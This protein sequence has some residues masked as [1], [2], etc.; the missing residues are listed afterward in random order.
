MEGPLTHLRAALPRRELFSKDSGS[1]SKIPYP[2]PAG[3][4]RAKP[5]LDERAI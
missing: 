5:H 4:S 3:I 1:P 2:D